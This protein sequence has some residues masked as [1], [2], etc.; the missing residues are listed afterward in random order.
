MKRLLLKIT[1]FTLVFLMLF[2]FLNLIIVNSQEINAEAQELQTFSAVD[3]FD[4]EIS[5]LSNGGMSSPAPITQAGPWIAQYKETG[6]PV[7]NNMTKYQYINNAASPWM[8]KAYEA[9]SSFSEPNFFVGYQ[10]NDNSKPSVLNVRFRSSY[11]TDLAL[12]FTVKDSGGYRIMPSA[13]ETNI[14]VSEALNPA[15][16]S[17]IVKIMV[18]SEVKWTSSALRNQGE[19]IAF[20]Q[21]DFNAVKGDVIKIVIERTPDSGAPDSFALLSM[22]PILKLITKVEEK[23]EDSVATQLENEVLALSSGGMNSAALFT[24]SGPWFAQYKEVGQQSWS[25]MSRYK[26]ENNMSSPWMR[27]CYVAYGGSSEPMFNINYKDYD[28]TKPKVV[29]ALLRSD[30]T[31]DL[32]LSYTVQK[33]AGYRI[34][35]ES[36]IPN[37]WISEA[38]DPRMDVVVKIMVNSLVK[39]TSPVLRAQGSSI[40]FPQI[41]FNAIANDV[42]KIV[43]ERT[44]DNG[45]PATITQLSFKPVIKEIEPI[46]TPPVIE[47]KKYDASELMKKEILAL[48][49]GNMTAVKQVVQKGPW[50]AQVFENDSI[51][52]KNISNYQYASNENSEWMAA[53]YISGDNFNSPH[54]G[55]KYDNFTNRT[56]TNY[57]RIHTYYSSNL[58]L[59]FKTP[60]SGN[61]KLSGDQRKV[62]LTY[63]FDNRTDIELTVKVL[64]N[65]TVLWTSVKPLKNLNDSVEIP[66]LNITARKDDFIRI[67][68]EKKVALNAPQGFVEFKFKPY[69]QLLEEINIPPEKDPFIKA[70][71]PIDQFYKEI[72]SISKG[73][74][75][76][77]SP[78]TQKGPW[79][80]M[81]KDDEQKSFVKTDK[82]QFVDYIESPWMNLTYTKF[83]DFNAPHMRVSYRNSN[84]NSPLVLNTRLTTSSTADMAIVFETPQSGIYKLEPQ[85][86]LKDV[87]VFNIFPEKL[88]QISFKVR[89]MKEDML[90]W[91]S[92][93]EIRKMN[94]KISFPNL[95]YTARKNEKIY[96]IFD[97]TADKGIKNPGHSNVSFKPAIYLI[98][99]LDLA[100]YVPVKPIAVYDATE[101]IYKQILSE[102]PDGS[103]KASDNARQTVQ[104]GPWLAQIKEK[105]STEWKNMSN[106]FFLGNLKEWWLVGFTEFYRYGVPSLSVMSY[107]DNKVLTAITGYELKTYDTAIT[108]IFPKK[109]NY[110]L[111]TG[112]TTRYIALVNGGRADLKDE[113]YLETKI[114]FNGKVIWPTEKSKTTD[115]VIL[116]CENSKVALPSLDFKAE[117]GDIVRIEFAGNK[118]TGYQSQV[119]VQ[120]IMLQMPLSYS[121]QTNPETSDSASG[122]FYLGICIISLLGLA[123]YKYS[124]IKKDRSEKNEN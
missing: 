52:Y 84:V 123:I 88:A 2:S 44:P 25:N 33:N 104:K 109:G 64:H 54:I 9:Y 92:K 122:V 86:D 17:M 118:L 23:I 93:T 63:L 79:Y 37:I 36:D 77:P 4:Q 26:Y 87:Y 115:G 35:A 102:Y 105:G 112:E 71:N 97:G 72:T 55:V 24:Q 53:S 6:Q 103:I 3:Q 32:A 76:Q 75:K 116:T 31:T 80:V 73:R 101:T 10:G 56:I 11:T 67:L 5:A 41:D 13:D 107:S 98:K 99:S 81:S 1:S 94:E 38:T 28:T 106:N 85:K 91:E 61:Y 113:L 78:M 14:W 68:F 120:P 43:I 58:A 69:V 57:G 89:I 47:S 100:E 119:I 7:W 95:T 30:Y 46:I 124:I 49:G 74:M 70:Y 48:S 16:M 111:D 19:S 20:P 82:F 18:N 62:E 39:W 110:K 22:K 27:M 117:Q 108:F 96:I 21:I 42:V 15:V 66:E 29:T 65:D 90:L 34:E 83:G 59:S 121:S 40:A 50:Y 51:F 45:A 8:I 12:S 114:S 60:V